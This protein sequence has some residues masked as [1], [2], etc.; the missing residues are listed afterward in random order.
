MSGFCVFVSHFLS[1]TTK[2]YFGLRE[3]LV[4]IW[5]ISTGGKLV[6]NQNSLFILPFRKGRKAIKPK[7]ML[8]SSMIAVIWPTLLQR[9][10]NVA[11]TLLQRC[12]DVGPRKGK[13]YQSIFMTEVWY[14][15]IIFY[16]IRTEHYFKKMKRSIYRARKPQTQ[17]PD[18]TPK[19]TPKPNTK[20]QPPNPNPT[21]KHNP[22]T[23][24]PN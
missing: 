17:S 21:P 22:Q 10:Y 23:Q 13:R 4:D 7:K 2:N 1:V 14:L 12:Y 18:P 9:C 5:P 15:D 16:S 8:K 6:E 20:T 24:S 19:P 11:S 3:H